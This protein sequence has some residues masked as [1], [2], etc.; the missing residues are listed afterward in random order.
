MP[1]KREVIKREVLPDPR[2]HDKLVAKCINIL[3]Y[4]GKRSV[5]ERILYSSFDL[6]GERMKDVD[7]SPLEIFKDAVENARPQVEVKSRRVG[8]STYQV[9]VEIRQDR[10]TA[11][12]FR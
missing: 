8:G 4:D 1:R 2:F 10:R 11:L 12:A 3:M 7:K 6:I 5:A 9:P